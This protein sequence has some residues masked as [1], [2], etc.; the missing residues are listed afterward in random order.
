MMSTLLVE[1]QVDWGRIENRCERYLMSEVTAA[2]PLSLPS[3]RQLV[4]ELFLRNG[5]LV[6]LRFLELG[7]VRVY[8]WSGNDCRL[9][10]LL[11][12][13]TFSTKTRMQDA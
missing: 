4:G 7:T 2:S 13:G 6:V 12:C 3:R 1:E 10:P 9:L 8:A 11:E 5:D